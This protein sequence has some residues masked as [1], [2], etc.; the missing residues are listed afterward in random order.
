MTRNVLLCATEYFVSII[1]SNGRLEIGVRRNKRQANIF[2]SA[3][4]LRLFIN[5]SEI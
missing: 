5:G 4:H 2:I 1:R 3:L